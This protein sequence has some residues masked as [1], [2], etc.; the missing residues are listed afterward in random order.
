MPLKVQQKLASVIYGHGRGWAFSQKD[1]LALGSRDAVDKALHRLAVKGVIRRVMRGIY[2]YPRYSE[3][4]GSIM[5]PDIDQVVQALARKFGWDVQPSGPAALNLLGLSTQVP[6]RYVFMSDGPSRS[7][8]VGGT[9][10]QFRHTALKESGFKQWES[11]V[12]VQ[13]L[14]SLGEERIDDAAIS[15]IRTWL[16]PAKRDKVLKDTRTVTGWTYEAI[17]RICLERS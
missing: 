15:R 4:I 7:Y 10:I 8:K 12:I 1:L 17:R 5:S 16:D 3:A 2:D 13:A 14:K 11:Q 6:G 9:E